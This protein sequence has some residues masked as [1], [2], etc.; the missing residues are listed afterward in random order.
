VI[1]ARLTAP[2][3][4]SQVTVSAKGETMSEKVL[5]LL[6]SELEKLRIVCRKCGAAMEIPIDRLGN[7]GEV[8]CPGCPSGQPTSSNPTGKTVLRSAKGDELLNLATAIMK[9]KQAKD[10]EIEFVVP[11]KEDKPSS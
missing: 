5:K 7:A 9:L 8:F 6:L 11:E 4:L 3:A 2:F 10:V 1:V